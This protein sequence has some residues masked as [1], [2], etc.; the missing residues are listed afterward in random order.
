MT[1]GTHDPVVEPVVG[2]ARGVPTTDPAALPGLEP[3]PD[4][5]LTVT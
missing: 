4:G 2:R 5:S 1:T 3:E